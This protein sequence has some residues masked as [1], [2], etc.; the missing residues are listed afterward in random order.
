MEINI[1]ERKGMKNRKEEEKWNIIMGNT[2][3]SGKMD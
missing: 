3:E 1:K 2:K